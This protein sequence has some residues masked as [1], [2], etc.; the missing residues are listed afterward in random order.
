MPSAGR[1]FFY[2]WWIVLASGAVTFYGAG[3]YFYGLSAFFDP[4]RNEFG[5]MAATT[6]VMFSLRSIES[7]ISSPVVGF[8]LDRMGPGR[9]V[10]IGSVVTGLGTILLSLVN[11]LW[12]FYLAF[13]LLA[14]VISFVVPI[15]GMSA[16]TNW[17]VKRRAFVLGLVM[18]GAA[19]GG[20]IVPVFTWIIGAYG[21]RPALVVAGAGM[22]VV[23]VPLSFV[24][25]R[26]PEQF[27]LLPDGRTP[28]SPVSTVSGKPA[29]AV[30][31]YTAK[32][33]VRTQGFWLLSIAV[34]FSGFAAQ[35]VLAFEIPAI[36]NVGFSAQT[37]SFVLTLT[38]LSGA[39]GRL[40]F[41][42]LA[43][44]VD[45]K[46]VMAGV[47]AV[48]AAGVLIFAFAHS[49][50]ALIVFALVFGPA[51]AASI[52]LRPAVQ[53][54]FFGRKAFGSI[55]GLIMG[56]MMVG[57]IT[58]PIFTGWVFDQQHSYQYAFL[59]LAAVGLL[60]VP[61]ILLA[62]PPAKTGSPLT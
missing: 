53:G 13:F 12:T 17:F 49:I 29:A 7:G 36:V 20:S 1:G 26:R 11:S 55:Q 21:W 28:G 15:P 30:V 10:M 25:G 46:R 58:S 34:I 59:G 44:K 19:L 50:W 33:A 31:E 48:Q 54:D 18:M 16:A 24:M 2:G 14:S 22:I 3:V 51:Y 42:W 9:V 57:T 8:L 39:A 41:G 27:G 47:L 38:T 40:L 62:R 45:S 61:A 56:V 23:G 32:E 37:A 4:I 6:A 43:D 5:W 52:S 35:A 60:A